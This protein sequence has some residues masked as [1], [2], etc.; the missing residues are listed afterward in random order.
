M[1]ISGTSQGNLGSLEY[2]HFNEFSY[3]QFFF[4]LNDFLKVKLEAPHK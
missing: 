2:A 1:Y 4:L 3:K